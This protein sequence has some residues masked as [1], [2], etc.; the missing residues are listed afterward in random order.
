[1]AQLIVRN[2]DEAIKLG[3]RRRDQHSSGP[4]SPFVTVHS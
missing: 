3:L 2:L 1:M 4:G